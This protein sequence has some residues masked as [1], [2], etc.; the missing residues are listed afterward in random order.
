[1]QNWV[2]RIAWKDMSDADV[3]HT[4]FTDWDYCKDYVL[5]LNRKLGLHKI[6]KEDNIK[7]IPGR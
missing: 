2:A 5:P 7:N 4:F 6:N 3:N 1:M